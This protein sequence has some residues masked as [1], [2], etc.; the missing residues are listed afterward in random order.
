MYVIEIYIY[1][2]QVKSNV[3]HFSSE[4]TSDMQNR[5]TRRLHSTFRHLSLAQGESTTYNCYINNACWP[6]YNIQTIIHIPN[7][8]MSNAFS[9]KR[10]KNFYIQN[11]KLVDSMSFHV[12]LS[13][14]NFRRLFSI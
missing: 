6:S 14:H 10:N 11:F 2:I 5:T 1:Y 4:T 13:I 8:K 12:Y 3:V 9:K 7:V